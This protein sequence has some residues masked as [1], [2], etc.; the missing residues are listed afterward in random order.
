MSLLALQ[1]F[2]HHGIATDGA[3]ECIPAQLKPLPFAFASTP[4]N[5][6]SL[7]HQRLPRDQR[8][9]RLEKPISNQSG[10]SQNC[11]GSR[12]SK[13][14]LALVLSILANHLPNGQQ[15]T[16]GNKGLIETLANGRREEGG[17]CWEGGVGGRCG[18][19]VWDVWEV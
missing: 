3:I 12:V 14:I 8:S 2:V 11:Y 18:K 15:G 5:A 13:P 6:G 16:G 7:G 10:L 19:E 1:Y 17:S 4:G 9:L